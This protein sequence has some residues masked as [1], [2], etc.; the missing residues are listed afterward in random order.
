MSISYPNARIVDQVDVYHGTA[1]PDPY[2]YLEDADSDETQ[3]WVAAEN[4]I[5]SAFIGQ[6]EERS[7]IEARVTQLWDYEKFGLPYK[8]GS[9]Y[10]WSHNNGLQNQS[11]QYV[12]DTLDASPRVLLDPNTLS[13]DGTVALSGTSVSEDGQYVAYGLAD[14][15]S[16]WQEW[17]IREVQTGADLPD[18]VRWIKFSGASWSKDGTGF[19][20]SRYDA[21]PEGQAL[22]QANHFQK[23]F[24]H[25]LGDEQIADTLVYARPDQPEWGIHGSVTDDGKYLIITVGQG[26]DR[27]NGVFYRDLYAGSDSPVVELLAPGD[28]RYDV[29]DNDGTVF[30]VRTDKDASRRRVIAI[31]TAHPEPAQWRE[32]IG[33]APETLEGVSLFGDEFIVTYLQDAHTQIKVFGIDGTFKREIPLPGIGSAGGFGGRRERHGNF[34]CVHGLHK[35]PHDLSVRHC[36]WYLDPL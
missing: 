12:A 27:R 20:Y 4:E 35:A 17:H 25:R 5:T 29:I 22:Q 10:F 3:A 23:L 14:A 24:F 33:E 31:D 26:T 7:A 9:H 32:I 16:D 11:V 18:V 13:T 6:V 36:F 28:A 30:Y 19:Y 21:P 15:G 1:V 34:L 8:R 2:R